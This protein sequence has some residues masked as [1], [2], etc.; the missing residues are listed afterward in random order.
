MRI[1]LKPNSDVLLCL[2]EQLKRGPAP[3]C[4]RRDACVAPYASGGTEAPRITSPLVN[5]L[6]G[7]KKWGAWPSYMSILNE[8]H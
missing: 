6:R 8:S 3:R 1:A 5:P 2:Q 4:D 7:V